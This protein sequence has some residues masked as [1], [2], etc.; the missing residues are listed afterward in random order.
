MLFWIGLIVGLLLSIIAILTMIYFK[1]KIQK[2]VKN[3]ETVVE[4]AS[5]NLKGGIFIP[6]DEDQIA[7]EEII[8]KN[9]EAGKD[10]PISELS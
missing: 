1:I 8:K 5:P 2:F 3:V 7:R 4:R 6:K 10:T 9:K